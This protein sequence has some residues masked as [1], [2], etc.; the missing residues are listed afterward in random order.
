MGRALER[1]AGLTRAIDQRFPVRTGIATSDL[2]KSDIGLLCESKRDFDVI[3]IKR[4]DRAFAL[5]LKLH[6]VPSSPTLRQR[7]D[8]LGISGAAAVDALTVPLLQRGKAPITALHTGHVALDLDVF[9]LDN[10]GTR[11]E[12]VARTYRGS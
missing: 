4:A 7:L 9:T 8:D 1:F 11:K 5:V 2:P 10:S 3:E 12:G 6:Q